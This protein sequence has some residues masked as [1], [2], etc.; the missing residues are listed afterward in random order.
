MRTYYLIRHARPENDAVSFRLSGFTRDMLGHEDKSLS[1]P[2]RLQAESVA[3]F[4]KELGVQRLLC[5]RM[6]RAM[7]TAEII[8]TSTGIPLTDRYAEFN[9]VAP[10]RLRGDLS[11]NLPLRFLLWRGWPRFLRHAFQGFASA[12]LGGL[13]LWQWSRGRTTDGD[14]VDATMKRLDYMFQVLDECKEA[15]VAV[16]CHAF[17]ILLHGWRLTRGRPLARLRLLGDITNCSVT[18]IDAD[19]KGNY[20]LKFFAR[21]YIMGR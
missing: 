16:V 6:H 8:S 20:R 19:G 2:G 10:G 11:R 5:S 21:D 1:D 3:P 4:I 15:N 9:E 12:I 17:L 7:E 14:D 13:S 18:R